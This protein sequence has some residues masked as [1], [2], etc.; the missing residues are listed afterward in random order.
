MSM[1]KESDINNRQKSVVMKGFDIAIQQQPAQK[2][3]TIQNLCVP[4]KFERPEPIPK[5]KIKISVQ[6]QIGVIK[7][8]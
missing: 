4:E 1:K 6:Q 7:M 3:N 5:R 8:V 2:I